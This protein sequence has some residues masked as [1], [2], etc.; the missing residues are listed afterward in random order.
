MSNAM[1]YLDALKQAQPTAASNRPDP[2]GVPSSD[3]DPFST[4]FFDDPHPDHQRLR[5]AG[6]VV[7]LRRYGIY[8]TARY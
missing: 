4:A 3:L 5:E 2:D 8:A 6:P 7:W 1:N